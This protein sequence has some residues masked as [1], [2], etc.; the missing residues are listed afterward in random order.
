MR[1]SQYYLHTSREV[2]RDAEV[3]SHQLMTRAGMIRKLAAGIYSYLPTA[4]RSLRKLME[5]TRKELEVA[6]SVELSMPAVQPAEH[7]G[8]RTISQPVFFQFD[9]LQVLW[10]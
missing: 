8:Y 6:G 4:W 3:I 5:I 1:W 7:V 9:D 2:P 10:Q